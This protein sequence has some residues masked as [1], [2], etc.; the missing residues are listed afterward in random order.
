MSITG[1]GYPSCGDFHVLWTKIEALQLETRIMLVPRTVFLR[2]CRT[3]SVAVPLIQLNRPLRL[4]R[5]TTCLRWNSTSTTNLQLPA[6]IPGS[7]AVSLTSRRGLV[8]LHGPDAAKFLQGLIT[9]IFP[10]ET[11]PTGLFTSFLSPQ[12]LPQCRSLISGTSAFRY[13]YLHY[14]TIIRGDRRQG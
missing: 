11:E 12:V 10:S 4:A 13:V 14:Y 5:Q 9:K 2:H 3:N 7:G 6:H 1:P 8:A